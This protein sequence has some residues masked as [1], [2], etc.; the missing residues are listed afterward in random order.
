MERT[1]VP[2]GSFTFDAL[3]AGPDDGE[4]VVLL[5]GFPES[6]TEWAA[7]LPA[8]ADAGY[9]AVA[10]DQRG[11]S[12][13]AR[14]DGVEHYAVEHLMSDVLA[15]ADWFGGH[16]FHLV[17]HDWGAAVAWAVAGRY[18]ERLR[19]LTSVSVPHPNAFAKALQGDDQRSRSSYIQ[20]F[21]DEQKAETLLLED[22]A[23]RLRVMY[24]G[25]V[26]ESHVEEC[27]ARLQQPGAMTAALNW[28]RAMRPGLVGDIGD[29]TVPTMFVWSDEDVALGR[30]GAEA[31]AEFC[32]GPY[33]FEVLEGVSHW[34]PEE[35]PEELNRL[36]LDHLG[37]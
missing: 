13:G 20:V 11:Y 10:P 37:Q 31:T 18:P 27:V 26:P 23:M 32:T 9:R 6:A 17:G 16:T 25:K 36:L 34:I 1:Q 30:E 19:T 3:V 8:L 24:Q 21:R 15:V 35:A 14:P 5:H 29:I 28:Y 22:D 7:Q 12:P 33:R 2:V 4:L